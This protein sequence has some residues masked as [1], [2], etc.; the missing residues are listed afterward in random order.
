LVHFPK[1]DKT[2]AYKQYERLQQLT[3]LNKLEIKSGHYVHN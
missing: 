3:E 2:V 1:S